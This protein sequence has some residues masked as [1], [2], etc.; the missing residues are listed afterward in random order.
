MHKA[1]KLL[2]FAICLSIAIV[3][4]SVWRWPSL[5]GY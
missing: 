2:M 5:A 3:L 4:Y 1:E